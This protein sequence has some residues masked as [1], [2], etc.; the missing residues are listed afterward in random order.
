MASLDLVAELRQRFDS[1]LSA[2]TF[3]SSFKRFVER[4]DSA[5]RAT[6]EPTIRKR[7]GS[8]KKA[9]DLIVHDDRYALVMDHKYS[10]TENRQTLEGN[11]RKVREYEQKFKLKEKLIEPQ[12]SILAP[13]TIARKYE[14]LPDEELCVFGYTINR[15]VIFNKMCGEVDFPRFNSLF[16]GGSITFPARKLGY[17]FLREEPPGCYTAVIVLTAFGFYKEEAFV[18][19]FPCEFEEILEM[20]NRNYPPWTTGKRQV[21][22]GRLRKALKI[23]KSA[24]FVR[25]WNEETGEINVD[26]YRYRR[27][28]DILHPL[29]EEEAKMIVKATRE[30]IEKK[31]ISR[32]LREFFP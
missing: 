29:I 9:P 24:G 16:E 1:Y 12:S 10:L 4:K 20:L 32:D 27:T 15:V 7:D 5:L 17:K 19:I 2:V 23:L 11:V 30:K 25:N 31:A 21:T 14:E 3:F 28:P 18:D 26:L 22:E 13:E 8:G 6:V